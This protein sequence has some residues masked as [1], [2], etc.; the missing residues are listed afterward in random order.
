M[1]CRVSQSLESRGHKKEHLS[2]QVCHQFRVC[3]RSLCQALC[4]KCVCGQCYSLVQFFLSCLG[5]S[6]I[7]DTI[8]SQV[9]EFVNTFFQIFLR[10][11]KIF[12]TSQ[13]LPV[14]LLRFFSSSS[15][16]MSSG[17]S[18]KFSLGVPQGTIV[19]LSHTTE[20]RCFSSQAFFTSVTLLLYSSVPLLLS[21]E[22]IARSQPF[23]C[24]LLSL[25]ARVARRTRGFAFA[26]G[27]VLSLIRS[28]SQFSSPQRSAI[29]PSISKLIV[30]L[31]LLAILFSLFLWGCSPLFCNNYI[32]HWGICQ[33][34]FE[35]FFYFFRFVKNTQFRD[36]NFFKLCAIY[37][38]T[39]WLG[40]GIIEIPVPHVRHRPGYLCNLTK[41]F[42]GGF[43]PI[44]LKS[45]LELE[46]QLS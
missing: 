15:K 2:Y 18:Q 24:K 40:C 8:I 25:R 36:K 7:S 16:R 19:I 12:S 37:L 14:Q 44:Y 4:R 32:I 5:V 21:Q 35:K 20:G 11:S 39:N 22:I 31:M 9:R 3:L 41:K 13:A 43:P 6:L 34:G 28:S 1:F 27:V 42:M 17:F 29:V 46:K 33:Q 26:Q 10:I 45:N 23:F 38:L 30:M